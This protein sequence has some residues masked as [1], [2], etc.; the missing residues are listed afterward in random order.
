MN[1]R[2]TKPTATTTATRRRSECIRMR[3]NNLTSCSIFI[4]CPYSAGDVRSHIWIFMSINYVLHT[5][6][7]LS[8]N[9]INFRWSFSRINIIWNYV[10]HLPRKQTNIVREV[11]LFRPSVCGC[12]CYFLWCTA[13]AIKAI[14][15]PARR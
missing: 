14:L 11:F 9:L 10:Q 13:E 3:Y 15:I 7:V 4:Y 6:F 8:A 12:R 5:Q 1:E 2:R